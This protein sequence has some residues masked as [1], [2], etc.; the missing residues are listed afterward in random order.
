[1]PLIDR[2]TIQK[3]IDTADIVEVVGDFVNLRKSGAN[4]K[5]LCPFHN[6]RTPSFS[7]NKARNI[8]KCF[9]C[10][11]GG[12]PVNFIMEHEQMTFNEA[13]HY[14]ARKYNIEIKEREMTEQ[15]RAAASK[16]EA[17]IAINAFAL[18]HFESNLKETTEGRSQAMSYLRHRRISDAMIERFHLGYAID[19][20]T[21]LLDAA[22]LAGF[23]VDL[24]VETG[25]EGRSQRDGSL[26]DRYRGRVIFP[27][28]TLSGR[29]V[30]FGAR[31]MKSDKNIA[32]YVNSP[33]SEIYHKKKELY[34]MYQARHAIARADKCIMVEGYFDVISM[35]QA[36]VENVVASS[37]TSLTEEQIRAIRRFTH[38]I[39]LIYDGDAAGVKASLRGIK[40]LLAEDMNVKVLA[41]PPEDDPDSFAQSHTSDE[42]EAYLREHETDIIAFMA[43][44]L[45]AGIKENDPVGRATA[46][47]DILRTVSFVDDQIKLQEYI[48]LCSRILNTPE[49][50]LMRQLNVFRASRFEDLD[51]ERKRNEAAESLTK[52]D[53]SV[54][55]EIKQEEAERTVPDYIPEVTEDVPDPSLKPYERQLV[56]YVVRY[57]LLE[58]DANNGGEDRVSVFNMIE[59]ALEADGYNFT[60]APF[61]RLMD[62]FR[63][64]QEN[65]WRPAKQKFIENLSRDCDE[66]LA[67]KRMEIRNEGG[68]ILELEK[69]DKAAVAEIE[70]YR[71]DSLQEFDMHFMQNSLV[72]HPDD[73]V[74]KLS[75]ELMFE[76]YVLSRIYTRQGNVLTEKEQLRTLVPRAVNELRSAVVASMIRNLNKSLETMPA[77][78]PNAPE[79]MRQLAQLK[80]FQYNLL[81]NLG[82]RIIQPLS[83]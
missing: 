39:T 74:R 44:K 16:S 62:V 4:Y 27:I 36:G 65:D 29:V 80:V 40:L 12:S 31:T 45:T 3:I 23:N 33:E 52:G 55:V 49:D 26:Y 53:D 20:G 13:L 1:M 15:E 51:K 82:D 66:R 41:L 71:E 18:K 14:L 73:S 35:H 79:L 58:I 38:N 8:C 83:K 21:D 56:Q 24:M 11:K 34:G 69:A 6:E 32:K 61:R 60:Y 64:I 72:N 30:G 48:A 81:K 42:V 9:S 7:V 68:S 57:G 70:A 46:I 77:D 43:S 75:S 76:R 59:S 10:G 37:G 22:R 17:L 63:E 5:G 2:E 19:K 47:N 78:D 25:L 50:V 28:H 54:A 67:A